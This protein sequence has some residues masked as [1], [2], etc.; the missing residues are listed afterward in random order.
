[1]KAEL[2]LADDNSAGLYVLGHDSLSADLRTIANRDVTEH[3]AVCAENNVVANSWVTLNPALKSF[4]AESHAVIHEHVIA[5]DCGCANDNAIA[6]VNK[7]PSTNGCGRVN[8]D[9]RPE[10]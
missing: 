3:D 8:L 9:A 10:A 6:V 7:N 1:V 4:A 5:D 2:K